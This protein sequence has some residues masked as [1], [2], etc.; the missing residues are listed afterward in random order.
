MWTVDALML[1]SFLTVGVTGILI[2]KI[3]FPG[4]NVQGGP[5]KSLHYGSAALSLL[6]VGVHLGLHYN[7]LKGVFSRRVRLP[8]V[9]A[10]TLTVILVAYGAYGLASTGFV[11]W[12][13]MPFGISAQKGEGLRG[14]RGQ[15]PGQDSAS[16][17]PDSAFAGAGGDS[18]QSSAGDTSEQV[19]FD[20]SVQTDGDASGLIDRDT[21]GQTGGGSAQTFGD[22]GQGAGQ[23]GGQ[24]FGG[25][26]GPSGSLGA[27]LSTFT[28]FFSI[29]FLFA[30]L[31]AFID[32]SL[33]RKKRRAAA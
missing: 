25:H 29:A 30:A 19:S 8:R 32:R 26:G 12:L 24:G 23:L 17:A 11:R 5:W 7:Y 13:A 6:W 9:V 33:R 1:L 4:L 31:T 20:A 18:T 16:V 14:G 10:A 28:Q 3:A 15:F 22:S 2:S 27:A 21:S